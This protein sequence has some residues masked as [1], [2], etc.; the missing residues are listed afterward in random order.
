MLT[1]LHYVPYTSPTILNKTRSCP[2]GAH[3]QVGKTDNGQTVVTFINSKLYFL[4]HHN[5][6]TFNLISVMSMTLMNGPLVFYCPVTEFD[7]FI[8]RFKS[9][10]NPGISQS[11]SVIKTCSF[12]FKIIFT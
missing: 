2:H 3:D 8:F 7:I 6:L 10:F 4:Y 1:E 11:N 5:S 12:L 9:Q